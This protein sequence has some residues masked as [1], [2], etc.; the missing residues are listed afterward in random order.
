MFAVDCSCLQWFAVG[1]ISWILSC[2]QLIVVVCSWLQ[3]FAVDCSCLQLI[4]VVCSGLQLVLFHEFKLFAEY[5]AKVGGRT[6]Y[7][8]E[9][10]WKNRKKKHSIISLKFDQ[11]I[12]FQFRKR[13]PVLA[14]LTITSSISRPKL[15]LI[16]HTKSWSWSSPN[17][18]WSTLFQ[19]SLTRECVCSLSFSF[20]INQ[21]LWTM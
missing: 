21:T 9:N 15:L 11:K 13:C 20:R 2:L 19:D 8:R 16:T 3:L 4:A 17:R 10:I 14:R 12:F 1:F 18:F 5:R 6:S 7:F